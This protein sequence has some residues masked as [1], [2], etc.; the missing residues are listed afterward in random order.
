MVATI[1]SFFNSSSANSM[2]VEGGKNVE[3]CGT[4]FQLSRIRFSGRFQKERS[5]PG[6]E[7]RA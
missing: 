3:A 5:M 7:A 2:D 1:F 4:S 6:N